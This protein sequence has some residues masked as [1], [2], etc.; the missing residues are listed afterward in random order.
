MVASLRPTDAHGF[1]VLEQITS[2]PDSVAQPALSPDGRMLAFVRGEGTFATVGQVHLKRLP[3]GEPTPL[4]SDGLRK[5]D[6]VFSPDGNRLA[7]TAIGDPSLRSGWDTW[8]APVL[9][10]NPRSWLKN[11]SGLTWV[12]PS[13]LLFSEIRTG[14]HM[15][16]VTSADS[17]A[18]PR[19]L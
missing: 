14:Q 5:M 12:G 8:V 17:R 11:A 19:E 3:D 9:R 10:G 4:T 2:F 15:G 7:Y 6:P 18:D 16:L 13:Q 1:F